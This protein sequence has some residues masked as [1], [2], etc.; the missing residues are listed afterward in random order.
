MGLSE[1]GENGAVVFEALRGDVHPIVGVV[2]GHEVLGKTETK[3][4]EVWRHG[5]RAYRLFYST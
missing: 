1:E 4:I 5:F 2:D 3:D